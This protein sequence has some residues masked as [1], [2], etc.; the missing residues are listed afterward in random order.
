MAMIFYREIFAETKVG[1][2]LKSVKGQR[3]QTPYR[4][5]RRERKSKFCSAVKGEKRLKVTQ[6]LRGSWE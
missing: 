4:V 5:G 1:F 6:L 3:K 2:V